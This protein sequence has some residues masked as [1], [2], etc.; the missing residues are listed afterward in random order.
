MFYYRGSYLRLIIQ[1]YVRSY[2]VNLKGLFTHILSRGL[3][4]LEFIG[5]K[6]VIVG[7]RVTLRLTAPHG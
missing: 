5:S 7:V 2:D 4:D 1:H 3:S 6:S